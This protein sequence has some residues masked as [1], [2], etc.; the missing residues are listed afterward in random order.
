MRGLFAASGHSNDSAGRKGPETKGK[1]FCD[2]IATETSCARNGSF[3]FFIVKNSRKRVERI[4]Q[5][6]SAISQRAMEGF[7]L[8][9]HKQEDYPAYCVR[10]HGVK[11]G[12]ELVF[13]LFCNSNALKTTRRPTILAEMILVL[14]LFVLL[15]ICLS[16]NGWLILNG[17][18]LTCP[19][20]TYPRSLQRPDI[21]EGLVVYENSSDVT[22]KIVVAHL[23]FSPAVRDLQNRGAI[24]VIF[25]EFARKWSILHRLLLAIYLL[26]SYR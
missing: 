1:R 14:R 10:W 4:F 12:L 16:C 20:V 8:R 24:G 18:Q 5:S 11:P 22:G 13:F 6:S 7:N 25:T 9:K 15:V 19:G 17:T 26:I 21:V 3:S 23:G 2:G